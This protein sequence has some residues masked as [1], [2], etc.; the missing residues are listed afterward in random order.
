M[1]A[2]F[3]KLDRRSANV[4]IGGVAVAVAVLAYVL[5]WTPL[6]DSI[7][8]LEQE[9]PRDRDLLQWMQ[10]AARHFD[11]RSGAP[12]PGMPV[13]TTVSTSARRAGLA[14]AIREIR[15]DGERA[16]QVSLRAAGFD[17]L[18]RW[19]DELNQRHGAVVSELTASPDPLPGRVDVRLR[20]VFGGTL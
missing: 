5:L 20:L 14:D 18:L 7:A 11:G 8:R 2:W 16:A 10:Q 19:L 17:D 9:V 12:E 1:M 4:L 6:T 3:Q 13:I 15:P